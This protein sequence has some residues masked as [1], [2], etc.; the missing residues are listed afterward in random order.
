MKKRSKIFRS[1]TYA[2]SLGEGKKQYTEKDAKKKL[3]GVMKNRGYAFISGTCRVS[4]YEPVI[5]AQ[6]VYM[7]KKAVKE[8]PTVYSMVTDK[9][10]GDET[11]FDIIGMADFPEHIKEA[12]A[13]KISMWAAAK[14]KYYESIMGNSMDMP[15]LRKDK[16]R[17][18]NIINFLRK[19]FVL[20]WRDED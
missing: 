20:V 19:E 2:I 12:I 14:I 5:F 4:E 8:T 9:F 1:I 15:G 6:F 18:F 3:L 17:L 10:K 7:G 16:V 13:R 11:L